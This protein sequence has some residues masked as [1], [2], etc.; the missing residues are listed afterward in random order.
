[1]YKR[2]DKGIIGKEQ[3][4]R[5]RN[6]TEEAITYQQNNI[7]RYKKDLQG[8]I[9]KSVEEPNYTKIVKEFLSL[10]KPNKILITKLI[11]VI[12]ISKDGIVDIHYKVKNPYKEI[13]K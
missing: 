10:K 9:N 8:I 5:L 6:E 7:N 12:Y 4:L 2:L 13:S 1:M 3:Y 11:K